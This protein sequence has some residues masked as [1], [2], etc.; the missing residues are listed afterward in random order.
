[1]KATADDGEA[2]VE[3][4]FTITVNDTIHP[5]APTIV[6][7][8]PLA[9]FTRLTLSQVTDTF[10]DSPGYAGRSFQAVV[11]VPDAAPEKPFQ[12]R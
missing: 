1:M 3:S 8:E 5:P 6:K 12:R 10:L 11:T 7:S 9:G 2:R 4:T